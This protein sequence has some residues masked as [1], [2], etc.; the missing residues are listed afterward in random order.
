MKRLAPIFPD[1]VGRGLARA[2]DASFVSGVA[3]CASTHPLD[4]DEGSGG[5][6]RS[7]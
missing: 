1:N 3:E 4:L 7:V 5:E 6:M 2:K